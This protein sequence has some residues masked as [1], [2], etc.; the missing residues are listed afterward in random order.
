MQTDPVTPRNSI[1]PP[2][3]RQPVISADTPSNGAGDYPPRPTQAALV[4]TATVAVLIFLGLLI[5]FILQNQEQVYVQYFGLAGSVTLGID[6]S[7]AGVFGG[8]LVAVIGAI[9]IAQLR[10]AATRLRHKAPRGLPTKP[11]HH[12]FRHGHPAR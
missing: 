4:W 5:V 9:R 1:P 11:R 3:A 6:R 12:L 2:P 10:T 7:I 8:L